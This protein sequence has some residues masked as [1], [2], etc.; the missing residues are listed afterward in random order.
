MKKTS[1]FF[2][3]LTTSLLGFGQQFNPFHYNHNGI[4]ND[5]KL[6]LDLMEK[7]YPGYKNQVQQVFDNNKNGALKNGQTYTIN[8]V[9]HVVWKNNEENIHDSIIERQI[10]ILNEDYGRTN[11]DTVNLRPIFDPIAGNPNIQ[12]NLVAI[13][14]VQTN[15]TFSVSFTGL[16]D[17]VKESANGGSDAWNTE[18]F[19]NIWVCNID[20]GL[21]GALFGYAYP[22]AGLSH[23]PGGSE[24]PNP[25]L[26]GVVLDFRTV[27]DN[28][29]NPMPDP[30]GGGGNVD[31]R[32][33]TATHEVGHYLG[34][35]H[36]WGDGGGF[37]GGNSCGAD[38]G[39]DDTPNQGAQSNFDC[40]TSLNTCIDSLGGQPSPNDLPDLIE[41]HMDYSSEACKNMFT[42]DQ[43]G[44]MR[45]VLE[46]ERIGLLSD[47]TA[48]N[49]YSDVAIKLYPN[50]SNAIVNIELDQ[51]LDNAL[52]RVSDLLGKQ[53]LLTKT[54]QQPLQLD[55]S[56]FNKGIYIVE[57]LDNGN[58]KHIEKLIIK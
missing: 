33:R 37:F 51:K 6:V 52:I 1:I 30:N 45:S 12:F 48:I 19:L 4:V 35:R 36:I 24:A 2:A 7:K 5:S 20:G 21:L 56:H 16:P 13:E 11:A 49:E 15:E 50:P 31:F 28:N 38:D 44:I 43:I 10:E 3:F 22:P 58:S 18:Y 34:L 47:A 8:T 46:N 41:N 40:N 23:W 54:D 57:L 25:N 17:N 14:R 27:G 29:P 53:L 32:G 55:F 39:C 9:V 42:N 26:E